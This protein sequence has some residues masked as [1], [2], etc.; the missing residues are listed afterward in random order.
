MEGAASQKTS[1][2]FVSSRERLSV[3]DAVAAI[4]VLEDGRYL[5]QHRD[6]LPHIWY[7]DHWGCFGGSVEPREDPVDALRRE[8]RE[9]LALEF[10]VAEFFIQI[11]FDLSGLGL[12]KYYRKYYV[13]PMTMGRM[14]GLSLGEGKALAAFDGDTILG[15]L[16][17]TPYDAFALFMH[18]RSFRLRSPRP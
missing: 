4:L 17:M 13:V 14:T 7:P 8:L 5:L 6:D 10:G 18:A 11:D 12:G 3:G 15:V 1:C 2:P 9:E 16:K